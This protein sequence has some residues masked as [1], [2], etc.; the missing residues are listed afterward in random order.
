MNTASR[1]ESTGSPNRIH[2]SAE[3]ADLLSQGGK[4]QWAVPR[5]DKVVAKGKGQLFTYWVQFKGGKSA[6]SVSSGSSQTGCSYE[7]AAIPDLSLLRSAAPFAE[8]SQKTKRLVKWNVELLANYLRSV[9]ARREA[10][11]TLVEDKS[12]LLRM[13]EDQAKQSGPVI[14]EVAETIYMPTFRASKR[15]SHNTVQLSHAVM[16]QLSEFVSQIAN[17]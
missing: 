17:V 12:A 13:E 14:D 3:T 5:E 6:G 9:V 11:K 15:E 16:A 8:Q 7:E 2:C 1:I 4:S 10:T